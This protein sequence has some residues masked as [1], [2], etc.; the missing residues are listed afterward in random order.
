M[1]V[2]EWFCGAVCGG[3]NMDDIV[4]GEEN[5]EE[6]EEESNINESN[7]FRTEEEFHLHRGR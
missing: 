7:L 2:P 3:L 5:I 6:P 1:T 4:S